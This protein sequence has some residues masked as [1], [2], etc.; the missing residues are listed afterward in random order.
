MI[1]TTVIHMFLVFKIPITHFKFIF[2]GDVF[3]AELRG[4]DSK[5]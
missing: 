1:C 4:P 5:F 3:V 2:F